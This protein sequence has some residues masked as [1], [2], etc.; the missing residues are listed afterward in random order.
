MLFGVLGLSKPTILNLRIFD[1]SQ[2][3]GSYTAPTEH[4]DF[5]YLDF[6]LYL[7]L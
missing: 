7:F 5:F 6:Y 2:W 4:I 3:L 1:L